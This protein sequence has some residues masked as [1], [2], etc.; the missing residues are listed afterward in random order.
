ME[1]NVNQNLNL[2]REMVNCHMQV[3]LWTYDCNCELLEST[4]PCLISFWL[5]WDIRNICLSMQKNT[6]HR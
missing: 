4:C 2:F 6:L 5:L 3:S 1:C